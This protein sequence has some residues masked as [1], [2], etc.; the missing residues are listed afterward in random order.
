MGRRGGSANSA[1]FKD[2]NVGGGF[3]LRVRRRGL[4]VGVVQGTAKGVGGKVDVDKVTCGRGAVGCMGLRKGLRE[5]RRKV[6][7]G[8]GRVRTGWQHCV[9]WCVERIEKV[10]DVRLMWVRNGMVGLCAMVRG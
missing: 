4:I 3:A 9:W 5:T 6:G 10:C 8:G 1:F 7:R 2:L